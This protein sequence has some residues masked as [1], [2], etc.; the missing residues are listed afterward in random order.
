MKI[1]LNVHDVSPQRR[2]EAKLLLKNEVTPLIRKWAPAFGFDGY[3]IE[4][5]AQEWGA[6]NWAG[7]SEYV[8]QDNTIT[9]N[10]NMDTNLAV[11]RFGLELTTVHELVHMLHWSLGVESPPP[12]SDPQ[13]WTPFE[14]F[15]ERLTWTIVT[16]GKYWTR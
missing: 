15:V 9:I 14:S 3:R 8:G 7:G 13:E 16:G 12:K 11:E 6:T 2:E 1:V 5:G 4:I 10:Y